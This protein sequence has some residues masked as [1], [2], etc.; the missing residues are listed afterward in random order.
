MIKVSDLTER[1]FEFAR[2]VIHWGMATLTEPA[3]PEALGIVQACMD[4][5]EEDASEAVSVAQMLHGKLQDNAARVAQGD[6][7][8]QVLEA[9][10][11]RGGLEFPQ[12]Q[13]ATVGQ[14]DEVKLEYCGLWW[15]YW[16]ICYTIAAGWGVPT[17]WRRLN[18]L[19]AFCRYC[20]I[21]GSAGGQCFVLPKPTV[22]RWK[23]DK[24]TE[25]PFE[26]PVY[27][28]HGNGAPAVEYPGGLNLYYWENVAIPERMGQVN[29]EQWQPRW[30]LDEDNAEVRRVLIREIGYERMLQQLDAKVLDTWREYELLQMQVPDMPVAYKLLKMT[31]PSTGAIHV[32]RTPPDM[33]TAENAIT[34]HNHG[35]HPDEFAWQA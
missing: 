7:I 5:K 25:A 30:I 20:P 4:A 13:P 31:C 17:D 11:L 23:T 14:D 22:I 33:D 26:F 2:R 35:T 15:V 21:I 34:W 3:I 19:T 10:V 29:C 16:M 1:H 24:T 12:V 18:L 9:G 28:L 27:E 6:E 32:L 8:M